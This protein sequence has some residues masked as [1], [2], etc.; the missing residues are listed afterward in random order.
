MGVCVA[1]FATNCHLKPRRNTMLNDL[2]DLV[3]DFL[4]DTVFQPI[5]DRIRKTFGWSK[6]IPVATMMPLMI[7]GYIPICVEFVINGDALSYLFAAMLLYLILFVSRLVITLIKDEIHDGTSESTGGSTILDRHRVC[8]KVER[9]AGF[10]LSAFIMTPFVLVGIA[11]P[12]ISLVCIFFGIGWFAFICCLY[13]RA[14]TDL[15][16][17]KSVFA[18]MKDWFRVHALR[19][20]PHTS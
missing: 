11:T 13:F 19:P 9:E 20:V 10:L 17:G 1:I 5:C 18:R 6:R 12:E 7:I 2:Y 15:P 3:D 16:R 8:E 4:I 14:C